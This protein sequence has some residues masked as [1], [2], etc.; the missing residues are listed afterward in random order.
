MHHLKIAGDKK[1][2]LIISAKELSSVLFQKKIR[3]VI[4]DGGNVYLLTKNKTIFKITLAD[5]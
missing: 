5:L 4:E 1:E 3:Q 2:K